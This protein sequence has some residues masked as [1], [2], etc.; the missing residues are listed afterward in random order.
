MRVICEAD[1][2]DFQDINRTLV[3][4]G[5]DLGWFYPVYVSRK[6]EEWRPQAFWE[7][8]QN[9]A[10]APRTGQ[11]RPRTMTELVGRRVVAR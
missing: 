3:A 8:G 1:I 5:F 10:G 4:A 6:F 11:P 9:D 2:A 7:E